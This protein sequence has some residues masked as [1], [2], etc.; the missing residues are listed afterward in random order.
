MR[1]RSLLLVGPTAEAARRAWDDARTSVASVVTWFGAMQAQDLASG[2]WSFGTRLPHLTMAGVE[3]SLERREALR[4]WP[5]RGTVH[6]V[7][8]ADA[9][10]MLRVLGERPLAEAARRQKVIGL[11][12]KDAARSVDLIAEALQGGNRLTRAQCLDVLEKGGV[13]LTANFGYHLLWF[14]SQ[15]G[16]TC[17]A[18]NIGKEQTF[19]LLSE[20]APDQVDLDRDQALGTIAERYFRSHG[21]APRA[22]FAGWAWLTAVDAKRGIAV[23]ADALRAV[24][25]DGTEMFM[26][27]ELLEE[28][29]AVAPAKSQEPVL[30]LPGFDEFL[31]GYKDRSL[32]V[33]DEHKQAIIPG[34]NG[35]FQST[36]VRDGA[37]I[38]IWKR[39]IGK[40]H[41]VVNVQPLVKLTARERPRLERAF[42]PYARYL[43]TPVEVR[44]AG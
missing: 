41:T 15:Q 33:A 39:T 11:D 2:L 9:G 6:F 17:I 36:I 3:Q 8:S 18:P 21:P 14:A 12:P 7:P 5:M 20:W 22:D 35:I 4:T 19:A 29:P 43:G 44:I 34:G 31:L 38:G 1:Q 13:K 37:V 25:V 40:K 26:S 28:G 24:D 42:E 10:W 16:V 30:A 23:A 27:A 32:M